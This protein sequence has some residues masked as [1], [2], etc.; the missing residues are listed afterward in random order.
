MLKLLYL[1]FIIILVIL[2]I[3]PINTS[4]SQKQKSD[5]VV[6]A[7]EIPLKK[8]TVPNAL[9]KKLLKEIT[10]K[11]YKFPEQLKEDY[12]KGLIDASSFFSA[13]EMD[14]NNDGKMELILKQSEE[15]TF[16]RGHNCPIWIFD[17]KG[18]NYQ[19]LLND[20]IGNYDLVV[21]KNRTN[22]YQDLLITAHGSAIEHE[23]KVYKFSGAKYHIKKCVLETVTSNAQGDFS[24]RYEEHP[25]Y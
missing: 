1:Y 16:C 9:A 3:L 11:G 13:Q 15:N 12:Q 18:K 19:L 24:Y 21:L 25:C 7:I 22:T 10:R 23:L 2:L 20:S 5:F 14:L 8:A 6:E 4:S 17:K